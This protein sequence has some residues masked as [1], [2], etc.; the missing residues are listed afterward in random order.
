MSEMARIESAIAFVPAIDRS[1]WVEIGMAVKSELGDAGHDIWDAWSR[2]A[3]CLPRMYC[4][5]CLA[6]N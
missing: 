3:E 6:I 4:Q 2:G 1:L 5:G